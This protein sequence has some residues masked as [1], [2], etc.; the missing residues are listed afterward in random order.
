MT[1]A[2]AC[3]REALYTVRLL[4]GS[5]PRRSNETQTEVRIGEQRVFCRNDRL[6][7]T[8]PAY[9]LITLEPAAG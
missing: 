7:V 5:N 3:Q 1:L 8:I 4:D 2:L 6:S 9:S